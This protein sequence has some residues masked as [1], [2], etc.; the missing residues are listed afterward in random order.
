MTKRGE[1]FFFW[2]ALVLI[3]IVVSGFSILAFSRPGGPLETP[4]FLHFH[5]AVFLGWFVVLALQARLIGAG[6]AGLH[7]RLGQASLALAVAIVIVGYLVVRFAVH[8]PDMTI[9]GRPAIIGAVFPIWDIINF[10][11]A[12]TLGFINRSNANAHKRLMLCAAILMIDPAMAR[13]NLGLDLPGILI[14]VCEVALFVALISYDLIKLR[15][16]HWASLVGL[17]LYASAMAFKLNID[18]FDWWPRFVK[19][20][21]GLG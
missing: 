2:M 15:R 14:L 13:L 7:R 19:A 20:L 11:I 12:Y 3:A 1:P 17:G 9:A 5:G 6:H 18:T 10:T 8:K 4:L 16:P 21:F